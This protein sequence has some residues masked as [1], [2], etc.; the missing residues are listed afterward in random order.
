MLKWILEKEVL[1]EDMHR[2]KLVWLRNLLDHPHAM[3]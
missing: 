3:A 2:I 1:C